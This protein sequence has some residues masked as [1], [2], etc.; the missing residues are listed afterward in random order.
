MSKIEAIA[1][2]STKPFLICSAYVHTF[3]S[4]DIGF[5]VALNKRA[6]QIPHP[7][8]RNSEQATLSASTTVETSEDSRTSM[9]NQM[10]TGIMLGRRNGDNNP[11][12]FQYAESFQG[13]NANSLSI[14]DCL[15][16]N[17][18]TPCMVIMWQSVAQPGSLMLF[19]LY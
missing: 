10:Q 9:G 14:S 17:L 5:A 3:C 13:I 15:P 16:E 6:A 8:E 19:V 2:P 18:L 7:I 1:Q 4:I 12:T 11:G